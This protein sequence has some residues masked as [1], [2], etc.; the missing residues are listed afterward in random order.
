MSKQEERFARRRL[1]NSYIGTTISITLVL[2]MLGLTTSIVL[3]AREIA[4][5]V[6]EHYSFT[7]FM[8]DDTPETEILRFQKY[9]DTRDAVKTTRFK[10]SAEASE[11]Y[12]REI[13]ED[14]VEMLG[15]SP[16][17]DQILLTIKAEY[18]NADSLKSLENDILNRPMV[19]EFHYNKGLIDQVNRNMHKFGLV[20]LSFSILLF[21]IAFA[22]INNTIRLAVFANRFIIRS[23][24]MVGATQRFIRKPFLRKGLVQGVASALLSIIMLIGTFH[25]FNREVD[26]LVTLSHLDLLLVLFAFVLLLGILLVRV[27]TWLAVRRY[28]RLK[29][30]QL[31]Q[32]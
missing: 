3:F 23:M 28:L 29:T 2:Y 10:S 20:L 14:F 13:G 27:T 17:S 12:A 15:K 9:L 6:K 19:A 24:Q 7:I 16:I 11:E 1:R 4:V 26:P 18:A 22:L 5:K 31:Y 30:D 32:Y 25:V 21:V 8:A